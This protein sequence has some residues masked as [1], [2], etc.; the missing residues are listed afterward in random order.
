MARTPQRIASPVGLKHV[1]LTSGFFKTR[2]ETNRRVTLPMEHQQCLRTG[3]IGAFRLDWKPGQPNQPHHFWDSDLAKW[4]E[5]VGYSL[6]RNPDPQLEKTVDEVIDLVVSAQQP[7]GYLNVFYTVVQ[8]GKRWTNL[9]DM[10]ELYCAG[11]LM[12]AAVA[13]YH[14]TGKRK[15][16]DC[17]CRYADHIAATF[18]PDE[19]QKHGYCGHPEI[20]LA[21]MK[22][23][24]ATGNERY[25]DLARFFVTQRG[26]QPLYFNIEAAARG[27]DRTKWGQ[28]PEYFQAHAPLIQ[29]KTI[30][31]HSVRA[32]YLLSGAIDVAAET[33][34][35]KLWAPCKR[36]FDNAVQKR[37]YITGAAGSARHGERYT[38]DY[39]LPN[40]TAYAET[41]ANIALALTAWR[42]F[43]VEPD[44][45]YTD[46]MERALYN[47]IIS[48]VSLKG[49]R[50]FY[51]NPLAVD[52]EALT[53][54]SGGISAHR[55][56]WFDCACCPPNIARLLAQVNQLIYST[57]SDTLYVHL[58]TS[59]RVE[60]AV[61]D[62]KII[63]QQQTQYPWDG[64][65]AITLS[66]KAPRRFAIAL[67]IPGWCNRP[68][69][70]VAGKKIAVKPKRGYA[71]IDR[72]WS[73]GDAIELTLPMEA[74]MIITNPQCRN[75]AGKVA[76]QR[77]PMVY[78]AEEIDNGPVFTYSIPRNAKWQAKFEPRLLGGVTTLTGKAMQQSTKG[79]DG[80]LYRPASDPVVKP[81]AATLKL[82]PYCVWGNRKV[83]QMVVWMPLS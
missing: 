42:M 79:W 26:T 49:D 19:A 83:G 67:R 36:L 72:L 28:N 43:H 11:H 48:G 47:G 1:E 50:F 45:R 14:G 31:G 39:D 4:I 58:Y 52:R 71:L 17:L 30:E 18:G 40:E 21:L 69:L 46:I 37:M 13:Y 24:R 62:A 53:T 29:Q 77:G 38:Y 70:K 16:L 68:A 35:P 81:T 5:A 66:L 64:K 78:C 76:I 73:D 10:H 25:R 3:R 27:E 7:D 65:I 34:D 54:K 8:P 22:L 41:C 32:L 60:T 23:Y 12:E 56:E 6:A 44:G 57:S 82:V 51:A 55:Q 75:N 74:Q 15:L 59:S 63:L 2:Q 61:A 9:R 33:H 80:H 20:E